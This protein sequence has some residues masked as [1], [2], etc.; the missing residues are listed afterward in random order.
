M[1]KAIFN[2]RF[3]ATDTKQG[4]S[5]RIFPDP[6]PQTFPEWVIALAVEAGA[7]E[8]VEPQQSAASTARKQKGPEHE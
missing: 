4:A 1:A 2:K 5:V 6:E 3:N 8:R 7:A